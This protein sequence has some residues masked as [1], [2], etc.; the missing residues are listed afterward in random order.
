MNDFFIMQS[1]YTSFSININYSIIFLFFLLDNNIL[2][3]SLNVNMSIK[4]FYLNGNK[5][6]YNCKKPKFVK[7]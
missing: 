7:I 6:E 2:K 5:E 4:G 3:I 1:N